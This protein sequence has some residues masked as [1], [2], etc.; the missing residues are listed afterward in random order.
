M[1]F[2]KANIYSFAFFLTACLAQSAQAFLPIPILAMLGANQHVRN[3]IMILDVKQQEHHFGACGFTFATAL[4][5]EVAPIIASTHALHCVTSYFDPAQWL[6]YKNDNLILFIPQKYLQTFKINDPANAGFDLEGWQQVDQLGQTMRCCDLYAT[7][8]QQPT[9][10]ETFEDLSKKSTNRICACLNRDTHNR[11]KIYAVGHGAP[12]AHQVCGLDLKDF[13]RLL[14]TFENQISTDFFI[15]QTCFGGSKNQLKQVY[16]DSTGNFKKFKFPI[17]SGAL[18]NSVSFSFHPSIGTT[19]EKLFSRINGSIIAEKK[20]KRLLKAVNELNKC[21]YAASNYHWTNNLLLVRMPN[22]EY[23]EPVVDNKTVF[24]LSDLP[25]DSSTKELYADEQQFKCLLVDKPIIND[26][27][28]LRD[29]KNFII[30]SGISRPKHFIKEL[31]MSFDILQPSELVLADIAEVFSSLAEPEKSKHFFIDSI[32]LG[33][34]H[35]K[36]CTISQERYANFFDI[37]QKINIK[38]VI[39]DVLYTGKAI[40]RC[41]NGKTERIEVSIFQATTDDKAAYEDEY[42]STVRKHLNK[43]HVYPFAAKDEVYS[44]E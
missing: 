1:Y 44:V 19:F 24:K 33:D 8:A 18:T 29:F 17:I 35:I 22:A 11:W 9:D 27:I 12:D 26:V 36:N 5:D 14:D 32:D 43:R 41:V 34:L 42:K 25:T 23:F 6:I 15:Y 2:S 28:D 16:Q 30:A 3:L 7:L 38:A 13:R 40:F 31:K 20:T 39:N 10:H 37:W 21:L 4:R